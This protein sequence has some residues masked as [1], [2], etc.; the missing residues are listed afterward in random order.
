MVGRHF[1]YSRSA[2]EY[3]GLRSSIF[4]ILGEISGGLVARRGS[5]SAERSLSIAS[6]SPSRCTV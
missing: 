6:A 2:I 5:Y 1:F 4:E 3:A